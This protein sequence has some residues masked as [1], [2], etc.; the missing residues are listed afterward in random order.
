MLLFAA[1][2][3]QY[4]ARYAPVRRA[5]TGEVEY[6]ARSCICARRRRARRRRGI[7]GDP[8]WKQK[9]FIDR[10]VEPAVSDSASFARF[11]AESRKK[12]GEIA[13]EAGVVPQ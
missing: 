9:N 11:I 5:A 12:A 3:G 8:A 7:T 1:R 4:H 6:G 10:A 2:G 13:K